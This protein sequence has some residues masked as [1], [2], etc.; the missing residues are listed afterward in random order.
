MS[1]ENVNEAF[2]AKSWALAQ[3]IIIA[4]RLTDLSVQQSNFNCK[5]NQNLN[6]TVP[7]LHQPDLSCVSGSAKLST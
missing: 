7:E 3:L 2:S 5:P 4:A 6:R 1:F